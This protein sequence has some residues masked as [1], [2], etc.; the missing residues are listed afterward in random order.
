MEKLYAGIIGSWRNQA[1]HAGDARNGEHQSQPENRSGVE[2]TER[3]G[4]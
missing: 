3:I 4:A 2:M 1:I